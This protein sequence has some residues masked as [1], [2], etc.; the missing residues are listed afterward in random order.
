M[1]VQMFH[2]KRYGAPSRTLLSYLFTSLS[3]T[4]DGQGS[5]IWVLSKSL[6]PTLGTVPALATYGHR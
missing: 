3:G 6:T 4:V 5:L 2:V 1:D